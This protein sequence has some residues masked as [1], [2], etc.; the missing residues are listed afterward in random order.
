M[1]PEDVHR[2]SGICFTSEETPRKIS[3][4]RASDEGRATSHR[5]KWDPL[6]LNE[7]VG[8]QS[9]SGMEKKGKKVRVGSIG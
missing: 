8:S 4:R 5:L 1:I 2:S 9:T 7:V 6:H 3:A